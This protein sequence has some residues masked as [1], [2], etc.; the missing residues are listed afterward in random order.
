[1]A[2][3]YAYKTRDLKF[4]LNEWLP[5]HEVLAYDKYKDYYGAEDIDTIIDSI[6][7]IAREVMAPTADDGE[8]TP[9]YLENGK[10][11]VPESFKKLFKYINENG[12][13]TSNVDDS[14]GSIPFVLSCAINELMTCVNP[15][16]MPYIALSTGA[17]GLIQSFGEEHHKNMFLPKMFDGTWSGTM[18]L[19]EA[20]AGSD[21]GDILSKAYPT[22]DPRIYKIKGSKIFITGGDGDH[23]ENVIHLYLARIDGAAQGTRGISLFIVPKYWVNEDG[24][25][26]PNDVEPTAVEHKMGMKGSATVALACGDNNGCRG[27]LMGSYDAKTG[28]GQGIA[29]MFQMMNEERLLTGSAALGVTA[30]AYW[31]TAAYCK[32]RIQGRLMTNAKAGRTQII[33][34]EDVKRMLLLNKATMEACRAIINQEAYYIEVGH[35]DPDPVRRKAASGMAECLTPLAKAY[36]TDEAWTCIC[37]SIQAHGGYGFCEE[38]SVAQAARDVKIYSIWEGTNFIQSLDLVGRKWTMGK[39][40]VFAA[41]LKN[42]E[43]FISAHKATA[44]LE[45]E[46]AILE[47]ALVAYKEIMSTMGK[48]MADGKP[49]MMPTYSRRILTATAQLYGGMCLLDQALIAQ[50]KIEE[51]GKEHYDYNFYNGKLLSARYYLRNVVPNVWS[52]MEIIQNGDTSVMESIADTFDY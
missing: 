25:L 15:S 31:N 27:W 32:E 43:D 12:W 18:C 52:V 13:G 24:S 28:T 23:V 34:H 4:I 46:Y 7:K 16:F 42:I 47:K 39:G 26:E 44:G 40:A 21:V 10:V 30:N 8:K 45:K 33:N 1:M 48:Y 6:D 9:V 22:D 19:T 35:L 14:G 5:T 2:T 11:Y 3:N 29:Q 41:F 50:K 36:T 38:Y 51:L 37:E 49:G 17:A 20:S